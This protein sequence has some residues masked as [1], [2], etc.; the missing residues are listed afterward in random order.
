MNEQDAIRLKNMIEKDEAFR[1]AIEN[2][3]NNTDILKI[4]EGAGISITN[5]ELATIHVGTAQGQVPYQLT[6]GEMEAAAGG[7]MIHGREEDDRWF[8]YYLED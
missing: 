5:E 3:K 8:H 4:L 1:Q 7:I 2:A 6:D